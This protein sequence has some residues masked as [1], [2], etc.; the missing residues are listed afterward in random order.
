M[1]TGPESAGG[2]AIM[3]GDG[4]QMIFTASSAIRITAKVASTCSK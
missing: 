4:P 3:I 1:V 2:A